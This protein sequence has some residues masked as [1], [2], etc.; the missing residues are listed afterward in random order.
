M[1]S[2]AFHSDPG[3]GW[4]AVPMADVLAS[5]ATISRYSYQSKAG[6]VAYLEEDCDVG[7]FIEA[8]GGKAVFEARYQTV[9]KYTNGSSRIRNLPYFY[10]PQTSASVA[11]GV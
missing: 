1:K 2:I 8:I 5:G 7:A 6:K 4:L 11:R 10:Q 3:H 9:D